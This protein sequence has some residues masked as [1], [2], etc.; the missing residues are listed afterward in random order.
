MSKQR[1]ELV[2]EVGTS[3]IRQKVG[4]TSGEQHRSLPPTYISRRENLRS[5]E[6]TSPHS[7]LYLLSPI[8]WFI[9]LHVSVRNEPSSS[10]LMLRIILTVGTML[11]LKLY[12]KILIIWSKIIK[13]LYKMNMLRVVSKFFPQASLFTLDPWCKNLSTTFTVCNFLSTLINFNNCYQFLNILKSN[14][15][16]NMVP[17]VSNTLSIRSPNDI[18]FATKRSCAVNQCIG[19]NKEFYARFF[20]D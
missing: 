1:E 15:N 7:C 6:T 19:E 10:D 17:T 18:S 12:W 2:L 13:I 4:R 5:D 16:I 3:R 14:F 8:H 9:T 11:I 20:I